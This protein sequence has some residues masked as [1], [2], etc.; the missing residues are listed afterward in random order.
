M[1]EDGQTA[2]WVKHTASTRIPLS[3][4]LPLCVLH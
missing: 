4:S 3:C 1:A 2:V